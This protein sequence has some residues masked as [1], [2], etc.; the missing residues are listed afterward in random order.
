MMWYER[1]I[2]DKAFMVVLGLL[3]VMQTLPYLLERVK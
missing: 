3:V 2:R 1:M